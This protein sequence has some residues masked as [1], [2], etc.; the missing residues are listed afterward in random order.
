[1][2]MYLPYIF[3]GTSVPL[4]QSFSQPCVFASL[5]HWHLRSGGIS[6]WSIRSVSGEDIARGESSPP[7]TYAPQ[8]QAVVLM[9]HIIQRFLVLLRF[10]LKHDRVVPRSSMIIEVDT[11]C[12]SFAFEGDQLAEERLVLLD[13]LRHLL[14]LREVV[15][16]TRRVA[17]GTRDELNLRDVVALGQTSRTA[18]EWRFVNL[19][20]GVSCG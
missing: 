12:V 15:V 5:I 1:M 16:V 4:G 20:V 8:P 2:N 13:V 14:A 17:V 9:Q 6:N 11:C 18:V 3:I 19:I 7:N 10:L